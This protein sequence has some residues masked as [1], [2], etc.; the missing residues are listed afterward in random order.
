MWL[1]LPPNA[2][3]GCCS[4]DK[5]LMLKGAGAAGSMQALATISVSDP[6]CGSCLTAVA[7]AAESDPSKMLQCANS[8]AVSM[9]QAMSGGG[10]PDTSKACA[11]GSNII[12]LYNQSLMSQAKG[13]NRH[14]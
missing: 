8:A 4:A 1:L 2:G 12:S 9:L 13:V 6:S 5:L 3:C 10:L 7:M 11:G 14:Q